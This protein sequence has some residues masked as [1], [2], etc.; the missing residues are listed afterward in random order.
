VQ[1]REKDLLNTSY[2]HTVFTLPD[3]L[4]GLALEQPRLLYALLFKTAWQV[5]KDFAANPKFMGA[6]N[7]MIILYQK[8]CLSRKKGFPQLTS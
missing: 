7:G 4:N 1:E 2:F 6:H 5:V 3:K 8:V